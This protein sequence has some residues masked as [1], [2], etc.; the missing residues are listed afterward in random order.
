MPSSKR[1][2]ATDAG[3]CKSE[4][5]FYLDPDI[6]ETHTH[7]RTHARTRAHAHTRTRVCMSVLM[8][9]YGYGYGYGYGWMDVGPT[10]ISIILL[11]SKYWVLPSDIYI[12]TYHSQSV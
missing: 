9:G 1:K 7:P 5:W 10:W 8:D 6:F 12:Y 3:A 11:V 4:K 2:A